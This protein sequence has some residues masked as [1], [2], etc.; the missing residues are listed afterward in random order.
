VVVDYLLWHM[1]WS[2]RLAPDPGMVPD[3][4]VF[5]YAAEEPLHEPEPAATPAPAVLPEWL[6]S[7]GAAV[8]EEPPAV[9]E[10]A[11]AC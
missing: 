2:L 3:A 7:P 5:N 4:R 10:E 8:Q 9:T 1:R 11:A 6:A